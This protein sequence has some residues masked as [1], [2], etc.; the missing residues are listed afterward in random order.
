[1]NLGT[2]LYDIILSPLIQLIEISFKL[3]DKLFSNTGI[4]ILG[5]SLAV[6]LFCLP[7]YIVAE[8]WQQLERDTQKK[9]KGGIDRIKK[10]FK[11]DEQYMILSTF[12]K[13][14]HYHPLMALRSSFGLLIQIPFFMAAYSCLSSLPGLQGAHFLFIKDMSKPDSLFTIGNFAINVLPIAMTL[15]N[16]VASAIYTKGFTFKEK[17]PIYGVALIFLVILYQSPAGL[18]LYWTMNNVFSLVKNIFYKLKNPLKVLYIIMCASCVFMAVYILFIYSGGASYKKR[19]PASLALLALI[20][21]PYYIKAVQAFIDKVATSIRDNSKERLVLFLTSAIGL[22]FLTGL[23]IPE[24]LM[25]SSVQEFSNIDSYT[26][27]TGFLGSSFWVSA[28]LFIFWPVCIYFLF[29]ERIQTLLSY[30]FTAGFVCA[31][32]NA[33]IF[34]G[35]YGSMDA[36]LKFIDGLSNPSSLYMLVNL[37]AVLVIFVL[38]ALSL[39]FNKASWSGYVTGIALGAMVVFSIVNASSITKQYNEYNKTVLEKQ[40]DNSFSTKFKLSKTNKNVVIMMLDRMESVNFLQIMEDQPE[41]KKEFEGFTFYPNTISFNGHT[42]MGAPGIYGGYEYTPKKMNEVPEKT[43]K[44][45]HNEAL[46]VLP[47]L[48]TENAGFESYIADLSWAN[49][50]YVSDMSFAKN[51]EGVH[52]MSLMGRYAGDFKKEALIDEKSS[53][54]LSHVLNR[55]L[56]WFSLFREVPAAL[57]SIVYYKGTWWEN[58]VQESS[59]SFVDWYSVLHYLPTLTTLDSE[60]PTFIMLANETPHSNEDISMYDIPMRKDFYLKDN[61]AYINDTATMYSVSRWLSWLKE[62]DIYDNTRIIFVSDHGSGNNALSKKLF[63]SS[64]IDGY[65]KSHL[66]PIL[67]VKDFSERGELKTDMEFMTNA[68]VPTIALNGIVKNPSNPFTGNPIP[69]LGKENGFDV[70]ID[71]IFM[72]HYSKSDKIFTVKDDSWWNIKDNIFEDS[73]WKK[74]SE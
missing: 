64:N 62:N 47:K 20:P 74:L 57:R 37:I 59:N 25:L 1:M 16:F 23:V 4:S 58:G 67:L 44:Q 27:P 71:D 73:N 3:F 40:A 66:N 26:N 7:L 69:L 9:L 48:F 34:K 6:T 56:F 68:D 46:L 39:K 65:A 12:Y 32:V 19:L 5:V 22:T 10:T 13:Q 52:P 50:S 54:S 53:T 28:G 8:S 49:Y 17:A 24:S 63:S 33:F 72:P 45:K 51:I 14:N 42:L 31:I 30:F 21:L 43:L 2:I 35:N 11:G 38:I 36:T 70:T 41:V 60:K 29:R 18:V 55:N 61:N 15:I